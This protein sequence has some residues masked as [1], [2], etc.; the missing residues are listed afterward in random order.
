M[1]RLYECLRGGLNVWEVWALRG[2]KL[3]WRLGRFIFEGV[4]IEW[5]GGGYW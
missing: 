2:R 4:G 1:E 3:E 5:L